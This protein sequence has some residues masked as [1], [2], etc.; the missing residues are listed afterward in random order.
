M[1]VTFLGHAGLFVETA[2]GSI[3]CDPWFNPAYFASWFPF[4]ANAALDVE[5]F[6]H[7]DYLYISHLHR[8]HF[9]PA[10]L[11]DHVSRAATVL[12][13]EFPLDE[14]RRELGDLGF[15]RFERLPNGS[16]VT[17]DGLR[18]MCV[19]ETSPSDGPLGDSALAVDDGTARLLDQNDARPRDLG[20]LRGFGPYDAHFL[21]FSGAIWYPVVYELPVE[22]KAELGRQK[23]HRGMDRAA[24]FAAALGSANVFPCAGPPCFL[25]DSLFA[26]NDIYGDESNPFPDQL[27]FLAHLQAQGH[28]S[29]KLVVPGSVVTLGAGRCE[30]AHPDP[31]AVADPFSDKARYLKAYQA[32]CRPIIEEV[33]GSWPVGKVDV[34]AELRAWWEPLMAQA[35]T[36]CSDIGVP[37]LLQI[38]ESD[39]VVDFPQRQVRAWAGEHCPYRFKMDRGV[40]EACIVDRSNDWVNGLFLSMRFSAERDGSYNEHIYTFFK[41]L[42]E[43]RMA[44]VEGRAAGLAPRPGPGPVPGSPREAPPKRAAPAGHRDADEWCRL[45]GWLVQG[46]CP[47]LQGDLARF[48]RVHDDVLT[49]LVHGWQ[50][51]L[52]TGRCLTSG[53]EHAIQARRLTDAEPTAGEVVVVDVEMDPESLP[54]RR[55][56]DRDDSEGPQ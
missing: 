19:A 18:L 28:D 22:V 43:E 32:R 36:L 20:A 33:K 44:Y 9:D 5:A 26:Y 2:G 24:G 46:R 17:L 42:S 21:Q 39:V 16:P 54:A 25:D 50:F 35:G 47:H 23:R 6:A 52:A 13:P 48:G 12:L 30:V 45:D 15:S 8:D 1:R 31:G 34:L 38:G 3:L 7:P 11:G 51:D 29:G 27:A 49:C 56:A 40:V 55:R 4:P 14:L 53:E 10:F 37:V 41:C